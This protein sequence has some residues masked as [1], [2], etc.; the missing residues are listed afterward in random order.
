MR[1]KK[2]VFFSFVLMLLVGGFVYSQIDSNYT[3]EIFGVPISLPVAVWIVIPMF[4]MFLASFFHMAYYSFKN[5]MVL[6]KYRK[7]YE[8]LVDSV[9]LALLR[10]PKSHNYKT[11]EGRN[12]GVVSDNSEMIPRDYKLP[13]KDERIKRSLEYIKDISNGIY[14]EL[15]GVNLSPQNPLLV[16]NIQNRLKD[17]PTYSGVVLKKCDEFPKD[18]CKEA[19]RTYI[20]ISGD[21]SKLKE[22]VKLFDKETLCYLIDEA[23]KEDRNLELSVSDLVY[24]IEHM[25]DR[26]DVRDYIELARKVKDLFGPD[27]RLELFERLKALDE[28]AEGGYLYTLFDLEMIERAK[29][30]LETTHED[31]WQNFKAYLELKECGRNYSLDLFV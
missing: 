25:K 3:F 16:K 24:F 11:Q 8:T 30:F 15:E 13:V 18:L 23:K 7:D 6:K 5:F 9:S 21:V 2:Y 27:E 28:K 17:E 1:L 20:S 14:V 4:L 12:L 10:E 22:Y 26:F 19:L 29:E 31:E